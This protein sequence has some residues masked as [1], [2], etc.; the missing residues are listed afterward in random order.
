MAAYA[1]YFDYRRRNNMDFRRE[2]RRESRR[3]VRAE[4]KRAD[5]AKTEYRTR[6]KD[7]VDAVAA[8]GF[9]A[10]TNQRENMFMQCVQE[11]EVLSVERKYYRLLPSPARRKSGVPL[12]GFLC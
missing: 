5:E 2:L 10:D 11:G 4:K 6:I 1:V 12:L 9:P 3:A 8:E 7:A